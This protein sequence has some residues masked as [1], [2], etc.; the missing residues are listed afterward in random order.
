M[1]TV[2]L[3]EAFKFHDA[4]MDAEFR[5][6]KDNEGAARYRLSK[7]TGIKESYLFRL[8]YKRREMRDVAGEAYR[9]LRHWYEATCER[10]ESAADAID[11]RAAEIEEG[12]AAVEKLGEAGQSNRTVD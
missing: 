5:G 10:V 7:K 6:R 2:A 9:R 3:E 12:N 8:T 1:S 4:L 11:R